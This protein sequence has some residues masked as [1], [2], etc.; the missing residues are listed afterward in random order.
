MYGHKEGRKERKEDCETCSAAK[1]SW[2]ARCRMSGGFTLWAGD[3]KADFRL[4]REDA[5]RSCFS[6]P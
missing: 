1:N 4:A 2:N 3:A 6:M 5:A